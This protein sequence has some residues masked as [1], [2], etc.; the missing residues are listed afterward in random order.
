MAL[1]L[2]VPKPLP[3][4]WKVIPFNYQYS[5]NF[6]AQSNINGD[7]F[8]DPNDQVAAF[9]GDECSGI[10]KLR[11]IEALDNYQAYISVYSNKTAGEA[12]QFR[13]WNAS[14][15]QVHRDVTPTY[16]FESNDVK[17]TASKP[18]MLKAIDVLEH[19]YDL[20]KGWT[21]I[22]AHLNYNYNPN[23]Q[24]KTNDLLKPLKATN[25]DLIRTIDA[26]DSYDKQEGWAGTLTAKG[27]IANGRGY[28]IFL[29]EENQ[30]RYNGLLLKGDQVKIDL[31]K[32][33]NWIGYIGF[34]NMPI[35]QALA[36][37]ANAKEGDIIKN[38][39][40][41]AIY[42][43]NVGWIG[44]LTS[45]KPGEGYMMKTAKA[46]NFHYPNLSYTA[47]GSKMRTGSQAKSV[48]IAA[49]SKYPNS[50]NAVAEVVGD[51]QSNNNRLRAFVGKELR[52]E[53]IPTYN[54]ITKKAS[55]FV[56]VYGQNMQEDIRFEFVDE[57][58]N[59]TAV[60]ETY[61]FATDAVLGGLKTPKLLTLA[62]S[63]EQLES[64]LVYPNPFTNVLTVQFYA[65][66]K[67]AKVTLTDIQGRKLKAA[68]VASSQLN[69][70]WD[71]RNLTSAVYI[72]IYL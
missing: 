36:G 59:A 34:K 25:G 64:V 1:A 48:I 17:G 47:S 55:Y 60:N 20:P 22:S 11:Y 13:I 30:L 53:A 21:W 5:M 8:R 16:L 7:V 31:V 44:D 56:T 29:I 33:W 39:Y 45:L 14:D 58:L 41:L 35:N 42:N 27:G 67:V 23:K 3:K 24:L 50:M 51:N 15:G 18:E 61:T 46:G 63:Q 28:K 69:L 54:P 65:G 62:S 38:Q 52:G 10:A 40:S 70:V 66:H 72:L 71:V 6:I 37:F 43:Q 49:S 12:I 4:D 19:T 2:D 32:G 68:D 26:V 57:Q 9:V